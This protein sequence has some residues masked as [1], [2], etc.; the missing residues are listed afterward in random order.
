MDGTKKL[1]EWLSD[2]LVEGYRIAR[3]VARALI[4]NDYILPVLDGLDEADDQTGDRFAIS[5]KMLEQIRVSSDTS[6]IAHGALVMTCRSDFYDELYNSG[7]SFRNAVVI[8][9][10]DLEPEEVRSYL[11]LRFKDDQAHDPYR[12]AH[13]AAVAQEDDSCLV[14][15]NIFCCID[16]I[17]Y[18][19]NTQSDQ[20]FY[21]I[22]YNSFRCR[23]TGC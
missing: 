1:G 3:P 19:F 4:Y 21:T 10:K 16:N 12:S 18:M 23:C 13:F 15:N 5:K 8:E 7:H 2:R 17:L 9:M 11:R 22:L 20:F 6:D 14:Q